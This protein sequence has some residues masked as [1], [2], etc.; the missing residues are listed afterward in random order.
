MEVLPGILLCCVCAFETSA[1]QLSAVKLPAWA[2]KARPVIIFGS[3]LKIGCIGF[4]RYPCRPFIFRALFWRIQFWSTI[5]E[6]D[7]FFRMNMA[8]YGRNTYSDH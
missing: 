3:A 5:L 2:V 8:C 6:R 4:E 7:W 1:G